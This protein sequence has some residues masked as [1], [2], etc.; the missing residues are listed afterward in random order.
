MLP[1]LIEVVNAVTGDSRVAG[2]RIPIAALF[3]G[4]NLR[5]MIH[6]VQ[7]ELRRPYTEA[8]EGI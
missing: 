6:D 5:R 2:N 7:R 4:S 1:S 8:I 3:A